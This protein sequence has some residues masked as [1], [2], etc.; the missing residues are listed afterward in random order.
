MKDVFLIFLIPCC[1]GKLSKSREFMLVCWEHLTGLSYELT[2]AMSD[3]WQRQNKCS[4]AMLAKIWL[5]SYIPRRALF[6]H[7]DEA[8]QDMCINENLVML[9]SGACHCLLSSSL[10]TRA[11]SSQQRALM[12]AHMI[13]NSFCLQH[14]DQIPLFGYVGCL[15][16]DLL[17]AFLNWLS[18]LKEN[19]LPMNTCCAEK[20]AKWRSLVTSSPVNMADCFL[21]IEIWFFAWDHSTQGHKL[22]TIFLPGGT[23]MS[24]L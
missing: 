11:A 19:L 4:F 18:L 22:T 20:C 16:H 12:V 9:Q 14:V 6:C 1:N 8:Q 3:R 15:F 23:H 10:A 5:Y 13:N 24:W 17:P 7:Q 2:V 21:F